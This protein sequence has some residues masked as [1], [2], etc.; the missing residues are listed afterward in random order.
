MSYLLKFY[1]ITVFME[2]ATETGDTDYQNQKVR[3]TAN[4]HGFVQLLPKLSSYLADY[5]ASLVQYFGLKS[6]LF[7]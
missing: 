4:L 3:A 5:N 6:M 2:N 7:R 1:L